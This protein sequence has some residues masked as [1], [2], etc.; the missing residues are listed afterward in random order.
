MPEAL[1][2]FCVLE[3]G[4]SFQMICLTPVRKE[5]IVIVLLKLVGERPASFEHVRVAKLG[6][7]CK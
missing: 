5:P 4:G 2:Q 7:G 1:R 3:G 6:I